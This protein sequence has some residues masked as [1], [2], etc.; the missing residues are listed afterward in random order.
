MDNK[1]DETDRL[2]NLVANKSFENLTIE[3]KNFVIGEIG[4]EQAYRMMRALAAAA[5]ENA[6]IPN[7]QIVGNLLHAQRKNSNA[8]GIWNKIFFAKVPVAV[9]YSLI[10]MITVLVFYPKE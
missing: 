1:F 3:E 2:E 5:A 10:L 6:I 8:D 7:E 9:V 4:T